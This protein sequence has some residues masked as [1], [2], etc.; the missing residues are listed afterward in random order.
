M[1]TSSGTSPEKHFDIVGSFIGTAILGLLTICFFGIL[2][3]NNVDHDRNYVPDK[4]SFGEV[5]RTSRKSGDN[6]NSRAFEPKYTCDRIIED[7]K[8][9]T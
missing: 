9:K 7:K 4:S 8:D 3:R 2:R 1:S 6:L 5:M